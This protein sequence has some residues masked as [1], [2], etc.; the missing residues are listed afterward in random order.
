M[1]YLSAGMARQGLLRA[2][3][4]PADALVDI[5]APPPDDEKA[6][7]RLY[8]DL[9][10]RDFVLRP[11]SRTVDIGKSDLDVTHM[12]PMRPRRVVQALGDVPI[13]RIR[14]GERVAYANGDVQCF[15][16]LRQPGATR[17]PA[18]AA[19]SGGAIE[20]AAVSQ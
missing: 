2:V 9:Y 3:R 8:R 18:V 19:G 10:C 4:R 12:T 5:G 17:K 6:A 11:M 16:Q 1:V 14:R 20:A 15:L 7:D 13:E